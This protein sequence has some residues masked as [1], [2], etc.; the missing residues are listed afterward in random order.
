MTC[1]AADYAFL[2]SLVFE[3]SANTLDPARDYLFEQRLQHL[4]QSTGLRSLDQLVAALRQFPDTAIQRAIAEAMTV[5]ETSFFRDRT[6]FDLMHRELLPVLIERRRALRHLRFWSAACSTGQE[7]YSLAM[8]LREYFPQLNGWHIEIIGTDLSAEVVRRAR[9]ARYQ[10]MEINRGL[11][12]RFLLKY[13]LQKDDEWE[14]A[15]EI[16]RNCRFFQQNLLESS[17]RFE[18]Y[19]GI[20]LRNVMLYFDQPTRTHLLLNLHRVLEPDGFLILG[21]SEQTGLPDHFQTVF[22][23]GTCYY[24]PLP[25]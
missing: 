17:C 4:I 20:L 10:R 16:R 2:R 19:D 5:N 21:S 9:A 1:S 22:A 7:A 15:P 14:V 8:L 25:G 11:P 13:F 24:R 6:P 23:A 18:R 3:Q 12:A